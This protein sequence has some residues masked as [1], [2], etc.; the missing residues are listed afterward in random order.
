[1]GDSTTSSLSSWV[2]LGEL[3]RRARR[4]GAVRPVELVVWARRGA[5]AARI[6]G[7][8][9]RLEPQNHQFFSILQQPP[10]PTVGRWTSREKSCK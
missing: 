6:S 9:L 7:V 1:M 2:L 5:G 3:P 8:G 4:G 10:F